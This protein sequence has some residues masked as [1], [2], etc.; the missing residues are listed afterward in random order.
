MMC[1]TTDSDKTAREIGVRLVELLGLQVKTDDDGDSIV[2][3]DRG[4]KT[5][6]G[7]TRCVNLIIKEGIR[8][9]MRI[10]I[11]INYDFV[12]YVG[13]SLTDARQ[14]AISHGVRGIDIWIDGK[15]YGWY[16]VETMEE[17]RVQ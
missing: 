12:Q 15:Q 1:K 9:S 14:S 10:F 4:N 6:G 5:L 13:T 3:T 11:V 7:L 16:V 17:K 2:W 8:S